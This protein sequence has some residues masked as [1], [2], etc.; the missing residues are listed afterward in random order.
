MIVNNQDYAL[1]LLA[2]SEEDITFPIKPNIITIFQLLLTGS[3]KKGIE[4]FGIG[5]NEIRA[6]GFLV[7]FH[8][9]INCAV[10][11]KYRVFV[12]KDGSY[13]SNGSWYLEFI[14][15]L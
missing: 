3:A 14:S 9:V 5:N 4:L 8:E 12:H 13:F 7:E 1:S 15:I 10:D 2:Q 6:L 11:N